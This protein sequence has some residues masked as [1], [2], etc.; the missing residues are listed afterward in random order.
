MQ[1]CDGSSKVVIC[2]WCSARLVLKCSTE[3]ERRNRELNSAEL[4]T[5]KQT[6]TTFK[7]YTSPCL[8]LESL[9]IIGSPRRSPNIVVRSKSEA[10]LTTRPETHRQT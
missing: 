3:W 9:G 7:N 8:F 1:D 10:M 4:Y 5:N 2:I 6:S